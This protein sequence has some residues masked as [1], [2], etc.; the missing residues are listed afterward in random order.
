MAGLRVASSLH[1][2]AARPGTHFS[3]ELRIHNFDTGGVD[4]DIRGV[5]VE[6][7]SRF[8]ARDDQRIR[9]NNSCKFP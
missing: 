8:P 2:R 6:P 4:L 7:S 3:S 1:P 9:C 5:Y